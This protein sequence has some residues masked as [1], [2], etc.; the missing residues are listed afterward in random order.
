MKES[1]ERG[2]VEN[3]ATLEKNLKQRE[4]YIDYIMKNIL[5]PRMVNNF[6]IVK[7]TDWLYA[8]MPNPDVIEKMYGYNF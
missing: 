3:P 8:R 4:R 5:T 2:I 7:I 1:D 6:Q